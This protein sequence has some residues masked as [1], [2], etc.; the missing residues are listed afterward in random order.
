M[1]MSRQ[2]G[3]SVEAKLLNQISKQLDHL[4]KLQN[5]T[6]PTTTTTTTT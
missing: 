5:R 2:K 6:Y 1:G 3:W 4:T